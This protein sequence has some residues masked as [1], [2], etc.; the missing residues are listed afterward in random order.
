MV[1]LLDGQVVSYLQDGLA[2]VTVK[3]DKS[4]S[5][6]YVDEGGSSEYIDCTYD[7]KSQILKYTVDHFS[8]FM[9]VEDEESD[10]EF[11]L[12]YIYIV[13]AEFLLI[14]LGVLAYYRRL[15]RKNTV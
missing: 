10:I 9:I 11:A 3:M 7:E 12:P 4:K 6:Y 15:K 13:L 8:I 1:L 2:E 14:P 5:V